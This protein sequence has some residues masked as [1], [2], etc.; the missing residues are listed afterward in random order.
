MTTQEHTSMDKSTQDELQ[1]N[2]YTD[3]NTIIGFHIPTIQYLTHSIQ[4]TICPDNGI[5]YFQ[6]TSLHYIQWKE[7][8]FEQ[9]DKNASYKVFT[10]PIP[11]STLPP[12]VNILRSVFAP[13]VKPIDIQS[14]W[15]LG[16]QH[17]VN[18][19]ILKGNERYDPTFA[20]TVPFIFPLP[21]MLLCG[22]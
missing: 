14:I 5:K 20:P 6:Q 2:E 9:F 1:T 13:S 21:T 10:K 8:A 18:G 16:L 12:D 22:Y 11:L 3:F 15:K 19:K 4:K 17:C 7:T